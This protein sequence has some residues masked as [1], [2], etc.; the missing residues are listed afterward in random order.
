MREALAANEAA[1]PLADGICDELLESGDA[2]AGDQC[3]DVDVCAGLLARARERRVIEERAE[4]KRAHARLD[5][6]N[7]ARQDGT[8]NEEALDADAVLAAGTEGGAQEGR[9]EERKVGTGQGNE[10][11][12]AA[13]LR[14][15]RDHG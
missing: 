2:H 9:H 5:E 7:E 10:R 12:L 13:E 8:R 14:R 6:L 4:L 11:V 3:T 15:E 1:S